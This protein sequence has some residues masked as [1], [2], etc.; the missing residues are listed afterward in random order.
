MTDGCHAEAAPIAAHGRSFAPVMDA[1]VLPFCPQ[2]TPGGHGTAG[3]N[4]RAEGPPIT[5]INFLQLN[6]G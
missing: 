1:S 2:H 4:D 3:R 6:R 5:I